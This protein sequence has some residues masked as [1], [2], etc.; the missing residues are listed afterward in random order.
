MALRIVD[1]EALRLHAGRRRGTL[2]VGC[3]PGFNHEE[4]VVKYLV[5]A[6]WVVLLVGTPPRCGAADRE[7]KLSAAEQKMVEGVNQ[8]RKKAGVPPVKPQAVLCG[9]ARR[10]AA[11]MAQ[12]G[13]LKQS[14]DG[15]QPLDRVTAAGYNADHCGSLVAQ[16]GDDLGP[17]FMQLLAEKTCRQELLRREAT[18]VGVGLASDGKGKV[19]YNIVLAKPK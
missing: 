12:K 18:E 14:F 13:E 5:C 11:A 17:V 10:H 2:A 19:F 15:K 9:C 6:G 4:G 8:A 3:P 7:V 1:R 16:G